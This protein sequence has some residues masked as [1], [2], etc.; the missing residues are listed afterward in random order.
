MSSDEKPN[1]DQNAEMM[2]VPR[3]YLLKDWSRAIA[4]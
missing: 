1:G 2:V 3:I 4:D